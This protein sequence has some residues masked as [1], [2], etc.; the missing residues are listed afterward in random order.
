[1][2]EEAQEEAEE[3]EEERFTDRYS[4]GMTFAIIS[5]SFYSVFVFFLRRS[6][7]FLFSGFSRDFWKRSRD[8]SSS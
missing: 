6:F 8:T 4:F 3:V 7:V 5:E 2:Q 1:M